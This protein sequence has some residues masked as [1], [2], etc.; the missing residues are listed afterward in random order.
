MNMSSDWKSQIMCQVLSVFKLP[1]RSRLQSQGMFFSVNIFN[2][3]S[4]LKGFMQYKNEFCVFGPHNLV[5]QLGDSKRFFE[6]RK[7]IDCA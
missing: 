3:W 4:S 6:R 5:F 7:L 2:F 1:L